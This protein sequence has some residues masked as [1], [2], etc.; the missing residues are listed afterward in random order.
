[1]FKLANAPHKAPINLYW[2]RIKY[3]ANL[4][5]KRNGKSQADE[6]YIAP[7]QRSA[8]KQNKAWPRIFR[9]GLSF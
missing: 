8:Q 2:L 7:N 4:V 1:M 9:N 3:G 5:R 6:W